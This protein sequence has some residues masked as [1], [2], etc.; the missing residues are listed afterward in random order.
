MFNVKAGPEDG[1]L[2][3]FFHPDART[4]LNLLFVKRTE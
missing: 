4:K 2:L 1:T 3:L